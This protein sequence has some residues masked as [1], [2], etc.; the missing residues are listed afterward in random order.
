MTANKQTVQ[1]FMEAVSK[2]HH[3]D[4]LAC[5]TDDVEW[6][7]PD[8]SHTQGKADF[9]KQNTNEGIVSCTITVTRL[10]EENNVVIAEGRV[11]ISRTDGGLL[12]TAFCDVFVMQD[13]KIKHLTAYL[14]EIKR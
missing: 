12:N 5:L 13:A 9:A 10:T 3:A 7:I 4:V 14:M 2:S 11:Q 6:V 1:K 8:V